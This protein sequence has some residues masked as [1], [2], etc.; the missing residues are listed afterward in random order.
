MEHPTLDLRVLSSS[1]KLSVAR[2]FKNKIFK[3]HP[4]G[5]VRCPTLDFSSGHDFKVMRSSPNCTPC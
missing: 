1:P 5:S 4:S 2:L 3:E